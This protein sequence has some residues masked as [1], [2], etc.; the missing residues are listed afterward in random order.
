MLDRHRQWEWRWQGFDW[1]SRLRLIGFLRRVSPFCTF[2]VDEPQSSMRMPP[3]ALRVASRVLV[4]FLN[5]GDVSG[6]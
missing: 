5:S 1:R 3:A 4:L 2:S 6:V